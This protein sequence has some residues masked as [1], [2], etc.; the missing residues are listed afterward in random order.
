[1][2]FILDSC[3]FHDAQCI[4]YGEKQ[5]FRFYEAFWL[6]RNQN[7]QEVHTSCNGE[8]SYLEKKGWERGKGL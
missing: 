2:V 3:S 1:M 5:A 6:Y 4:I 8:I 7:I